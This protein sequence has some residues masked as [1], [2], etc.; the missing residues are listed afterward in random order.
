MNP[1]MTKKSGTP[2][3][4]CLVNPASQSWAA[5]AP[6]KWRDFD[7]IWPVRWNKNTEAMAINRKPS[8]SGMNRPDDVTREKW[9]RNRSLWVK[10]VPFLLS[11]EFRPRLVTEV[12]GGRAAGPDVFP[13]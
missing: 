11:P 5:S 12:T 3:S 4:P 1:L 10:W 2:W 8:I 7:P 13:A 6:V 9:L